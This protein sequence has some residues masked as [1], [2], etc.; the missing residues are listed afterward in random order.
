MILLPH[1]I[2]DSSNKISTNGVFVPSGITTPQQLSSLRISFPQDIGDSQPCGHCGVFRG[3]LLQL[4]KSLQNWPHIEIHCG[5]RL[6]LKP[7]PPPPLPNFVFFLGICIVTDI[8]LHKP[9]SSRRAPAF[10]LLSNSL[11]IHMNRWKNGCS[12]YFCIIFQY[13]AAVYC[14]K[15]SE[16]IPFFK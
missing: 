1:W 7:H 11:P 9:S 12:F 8:W 15:M 10:S 13:S 3:I 14:L 16:A 6:R 5:R 2:V 4:L